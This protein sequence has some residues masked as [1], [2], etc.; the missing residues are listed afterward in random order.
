MRVL[1][2][3]LLFALL[4]G[5]P[6]APAAYGAEP[7][8]APQLP[9]EI[10]PQAAAL[11]P[12]FQSDLAD[13]ALWDRY[14]IEAAIAPNQRTISGS[15]SLAYTNRDSAPL[16]AIYLRLF[17]NLP[18]FGGRLDVADVTVNGAPARTDLEHGRFALRVELPQPLDPGATATVALTF[19]ARVPLN[20][21]ARFYGAF[22]L[23]GGVMALASFYP[24]AAQV[25]GGAWDIARP[26]VR[27]DFVNS[28]TALYDVTLAAP[29]DWSLATTGTAIEQRVERG[30]QIVR[31]T[32]GP[33][34]DFT[35]AATRLRVVSAEVDGTTINSYYRAGNPI[36]GRTAL[37]A[38]A[39]ALRIFNARFGPY[40]FSELDVV[41]FDARKFLGVEYP[42]LIFIDSR[43]Y[44]GR[45]GL[46]I[47][48]AHEVAH[49]WWY[50][51]VGNDVQREAWLDEALASYSQVVYREARYGGEAAARELAGFRSTYLRAR[52][53]GL[54]AAIARPVAEFRGNYVALVYAKGALFFGALRQEIGDEA[55]DRFLRDYYAA[56]RYREATGA[57]LLATAENACTCELDDF[58]RAWIESA[59]PVALP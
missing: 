16:D 52:Q 7:A 47:T 20:A 39:E 26:S 11:L 40:P 36:N 25:R 56:S 53:S 57:T 4:A 59:E 44:T 51:L 54:D 23:E 18:E 27:G 3:L 50:S 22:N 55:F 8:P 29:T 28:V 24:I 5:V 41:Q 10:A 12:A 42:G 14:T 38:A 6:A 2:P 33:Q 35:I 21:A 34:R 49:Q 45:A 30:R 1:V 19:N 48:V 31:Y 37:N 43:L 58:Y 9:A 13:A 17:P 46:E 15:Q 32:S